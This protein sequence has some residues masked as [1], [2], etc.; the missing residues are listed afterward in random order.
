MANLVFPFE[1][2]R[3]IV[4]PID[5]VLTLGTGPSN[6][7]VIEDPT[8]GHNHAE[9]VPDG[10]GAFV[11]RDLGTPSG[12]Y[13]NGKKVDS[14]TLSENDEIGFGSVRGWFRFGEHIAAPAATTGTTP[15]PTAPAPLESELKE[16]KGKLE[17]I[18]KEK[19]ARQQEVD[20]LRELIAGLN[21]ELGGVRKELQQAATEKKPERTRGEGAAW[22][23]GKEKARRPSARRSLRKQAKET[24]RKRSRGFRET[25]KQRDEAKAAAEKASKEL[26]ESKKAPAPA[27]KPSDEAGEKTGG[28][29][30]ET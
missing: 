29:P 26:A 13:V 23:K 7:V 21:K 16:Q 3:E 8:I 24:R 1:D 2:G 12:S 5:G 25:E 14:H 17:A 6:N 22:E 9:I 4:V 11:F 15:I 28:Y 18:E 27:G 20:K 10:K 30:V 19:A